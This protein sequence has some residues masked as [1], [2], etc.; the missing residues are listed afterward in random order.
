MDVFF[1]ALM[2]HDQT[3][4]KSHVRKR[5]VQVP[6]HAEAGAATHPGIY[7]ILKTVI[8]IAGTSGRTRRFQADNL[9]EVL[10]GDS[11]KSVAQLE[12]LLPSRL[13]HRRKDSN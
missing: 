6:S 3:G 7:I 8:Q 11:G 4:R 13:F 1:F 12:N 10:V 5:L 2:A 9:C